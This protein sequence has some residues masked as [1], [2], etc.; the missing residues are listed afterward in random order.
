MIQESRA[1]LAPLG[2]NNTRVSLAALKAAPI[3][4]RTSLYDGSVWTWT[5]GDFSTLVLSQPSRYVT[6]DSTPATSERRVGVRQQFAALSFG[7][8]EPTSAAIGTEVL[9]SVTS[10]VHNTGFG[11]QALKANGAG[12]EN[13]GFGYKALSSVTGS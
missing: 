8:L 4:D 1:P 13:T 5:A 3:S 7:V 6:S 10:G 12:N 9:A 11:F 2:L